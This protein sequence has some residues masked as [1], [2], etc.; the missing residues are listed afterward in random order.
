MTDWWIAR[1]P[2]GIKI[3]YGVPEG[4]DPNEGEKTMPC[5]GGKGKGKGKGSKGKG[6]R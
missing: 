2:G 4:V 3:L 5:H 1:I 6:K